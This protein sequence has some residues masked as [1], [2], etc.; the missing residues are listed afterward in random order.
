[1]ACARCQQQR[2]AVKNNIRSGNIVGAA[3]ETARGLGM[4]AGVIPKET[5]KPKATPLSRQP[6]ADLLKVTRTNKDR[7]HGK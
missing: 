6:F 3:K 1:M 4:M 2:A 5:T 7:G